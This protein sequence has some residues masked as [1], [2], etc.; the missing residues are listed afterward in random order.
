[1][2]A[3]IAA[4]QGDLDVTKIEA[5]LG[6]QW[7]NDEQLKDRDH[8][9]SREVRRFT[10]AAAFF[11]NDAQTWTDEKELFESGLGVGP[12][13]SEGVDIDSDGAEAL[14]VMEDE[15]DTAYAQ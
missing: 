2:A 11:G 14:A 7:A 6:T 10:A 3:V 13:D 9:K 8:R 1:M 12:A 4:V 5:A 15:A